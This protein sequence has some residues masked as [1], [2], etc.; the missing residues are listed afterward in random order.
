M[1]APVTVEG[2]AYLCF[3][4]DGSCFQGILLTN[5]KHQYG[6]QGEN[7]EASPG[8]DLHE[9]CHETAP[10]VMQIKLIDFGGVEFEKDIVISDVLRTG[11]DNCMLH[12]EELE[13]TTDQLLVD[14]KAESFIQKYLSQN[15]LG[16]DCYICI[17]DIN[18]SCS[19]VCTS[20]KFKE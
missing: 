4:E 17:G 18:I 10:V 12:S 13:F 19:N 5:T 8:L 15:V 1:A 16:K 11:G 3:A 14:K 2:T 6:L 7:M 9:C 20:V